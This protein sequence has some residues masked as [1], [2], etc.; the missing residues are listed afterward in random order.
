MGFPSQIKGHRL[1]NIPEYCGNGIP[2]KVLQ[3]MI[4]W[5]DSNPALTRFTQEDA[6][7]YHK[8][9]FLFAGLAR[10]LVGKKAYISYALWNEADGW[11]FVVDIADVRPVGN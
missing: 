7:Y 3:A 10:V 8:R 1:V 9:R 11:V 2:K 4:P 6:V 5:G